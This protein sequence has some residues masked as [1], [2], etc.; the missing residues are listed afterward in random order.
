M[1]LIKATGKKQ[2][3]Y[4]ASQFFYLALLV[5]LAGATTNASTD[6]SQYS[7]PR[8]HWLGLACETY[9]LPVYFSKS[10]GQLSCCSGYGLFV[11]HVCTAFIPFGL[12]VNLS[13]SFQTV[14]PGL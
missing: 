9:T 12:L 3:G 1:C 10:F 11:W 7:D 5:R 6:Q 14:Q 13:A 4:E 8:W 2:S